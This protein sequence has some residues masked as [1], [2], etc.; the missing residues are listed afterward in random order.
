[1]SKLI[2]VTGA[3]GFAGRHVIAALLAEG[4]RVQALVRNPAMARLTDDVVLVQGD[5]A[6]PDALELLVEGADAVIH[7]AG[8]ITANSAPEYFRVNA[9]GTL[10]LAESA[11][12]AGVRRFVHVSSLSAREPAISD[13]G[14]S[15]REGEDAVA[16]LMEALNAII[17]RP[18]AVYGPGDRATLP[19][20]KELTRPVAAIPGRREARFSLILVADLARLIAKAVE[21]DLTGRHEVSDQTP[22]GYGWPDLLRVASAVRGSA[23]RPV[24]LPR[25]IPQ[26]VALAAESVAKIRRKPGMIN[27]GKI[28]ELYHPDWVSG[29]SGL[30]LPQP[31]TF[32]QGFPETLDWYRQAGWLPQSAGA[33]RSSG[34]TKHR[35]RS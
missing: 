20:L 18:P 23:I 8:A 13:Y 16:S 35:T 24:F 12:R 27:R 30:T 22:G 28:A 34:E 19:L 9:Q 14:A 4:Y 25:A 3:T 7:L 15:K 6:T 1:M 31:I 29:P 21:S 11:Q 2:A 32:E 33:D 10:A 26:A 17:L 5:L